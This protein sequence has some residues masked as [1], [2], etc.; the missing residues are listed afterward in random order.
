MMMSA[1]T[2]YQTVSL[3][4]RRTGAALNLFYR[5]AGPKDAPAVLLLHGFPSS[6]HQYR[7]LIDRLSDKYR[8]IAPDLPG[9]GFSDAPDAKTFGYT[10][11]HLAEVLES[12]TDSL[13]TKL[14]ASEEVVNTIRHGG[15]FSDPKLEAVRLFTAAIA[16]KR[17]QVSDSDV[18]KLLAA[19][20]DR[21]A[22]IALALAAGAKTLVNTVT[23]LSRPI[24]D[25]GFMP[26]QRSLRRCW[27]GTAPSIAWQ[28][29]PSER[30]LERNPTLQL[31]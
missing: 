31:L 21:R 27:M 18:K 30:H 29:T 17:T 15:S 11:D 9:F 19:G 2:T 20:Y 8:V 13:A 6:S 24:P 23:H 1:P 25:P 5:E 16:S 22:V 10:F 26:I 12:F 4:D 28:S 14:G 7:G 3:T